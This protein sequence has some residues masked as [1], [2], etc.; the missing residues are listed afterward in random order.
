MKILSR[1]V[2]KALLFTCAALAPVTGTAAA[3]AEKELFELPRA[4]AA[5]AID[6]NLDDAAWQSRAARPRLLAH[7]T[8]R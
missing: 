6:G 1:G 7:A 3:A 4:A 2:A 5:P 8:T